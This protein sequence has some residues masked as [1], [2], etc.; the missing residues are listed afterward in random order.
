MAHPSASHPTKQS[1][2]QLF[3]RV[4]NESIC[5]QIRIVGIL[6]RRM[7]TDDIIDIKMLLVI[8][9]YSPPVSH[10]HS[11]ILQFAG[12]EEISAACITVN[13]Q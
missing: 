13:I 2:N 1:V 9:G 12:K 11:D 7:R 8:H 3:P 4:K 5:K 10:E 6:G